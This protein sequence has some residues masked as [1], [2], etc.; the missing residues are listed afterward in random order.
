MC[1]LA[2]VLELLDERVECK[3]YSQVGMS[4]FDLKGFD[5]SC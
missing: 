2:Q 4:G 5:N 3:R 1:L